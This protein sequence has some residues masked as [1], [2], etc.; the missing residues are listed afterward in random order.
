M[1]ARTL[2]RPGGTALVVIDLQE[3]LVQ[4]VP[5]SAAQGVIRTTVKLISL[6][7]ILEVPVLWSEQY[8]AGLGA[9]VAELADLLQ[10]YPRFEKTV[11]GC[12]GVPGFGGWLWEHGI[13][14]LLLTGI[15]THICVM[16]TALQALQ[17][18]L[19]VH[20]LSDAVA[21]YNQRCHD[22][23]LERIRQAGGVISS[24]ECAVYELMGR[25]GTPTFKAALP[26]L[27][28]RD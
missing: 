1:S 5:E 8:P 19:T 26:Y 4:M 28:D 6:M 7:G 3:K 18:G 22:L 17:A 20:V 21:A 9:T 25:A 12:F 27:K 16:Q 15:E 23:G 24:W 13:S 14:R 10:G 2:L 11:F